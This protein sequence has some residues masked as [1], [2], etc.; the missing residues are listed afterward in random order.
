MKILNLFKQF[1]R[2]I[3]LIIITTL[4]ISCVGVYA[5]GECIIS[6]TADDVTYGNTTVQAAIDELYSMTGSYCPP[7]YDCTKMA[8]IKATPSNDITAFRSDT[9]R[10]K[11]KTIT[12]DDQI[13]P[14]A[15]VIESWDIGEHQNGDVM[16]Y[17]TQNIDDNTMYDLYIQGDGSLYANEDSSYFLYN[18]KGIDS[19]NGIRKLNTS[20]VENM[21][22]MFHNTGY[23]S[24]SLTLDL[25]DNFDTSNVADMTYMFYQTGYNSQSVVIDLGNSFDTS[26]VADMPYMFALTGFNSPSLTIDLGDNFDTGNVGDMGR[27]FYRTG[28]D[29]TNFSLSLGN[30][31]DTSN[32]TDM[33]RMFQDVGYSSPSFTLNL[34]NS[35]YTNNVANMDLMFS[36]TGYANTT[37][38][39]DL[40]TFNFSNVTS[41]TNIFSQFKTTQ[42]IYVGN[43]TA[44]NW[45][46]TNS[47]NSN[48]TTSNV[49][50]KT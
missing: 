24:Q 11:I 43:A 5:A 37:F 15:N 38:E 7:D 9:Y 40:S 44:Q 13:N 32:V 50:I 41:Y 47:G 36:R 26:N 18:L 14:P 12:L 35:F 29:S 27:M 17:I 19:I 22:H 8:I 2:D 46:I 16:A 28:F 10:E 25:R 21:S 1:S 20:R 23:S 31:F 42:K 49:L 4:I 39:L 6:A 33:N 45:I 30:K 48:L 3:K 34:G